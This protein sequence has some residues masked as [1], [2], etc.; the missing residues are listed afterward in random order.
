[1]NPP[2]LVVLIT[3]AAGA[4]LWIDADQIESVKECSPTWCDRTYAGSHS[5]IDHCIVRT[6]T[7]AEYIISGHA[8]EVLEKMRDAYRELPRS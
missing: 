4:T 3:A 8:A 5:E 2:R 6:K 1:M 7:A